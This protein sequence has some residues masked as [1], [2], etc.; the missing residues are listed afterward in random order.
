MQR[1]IA[2][3]DGAAALALVQPC[4][5]DK[6]E[7]FI[8][9]LIVCVPREAKVPCRPVTFQQLS[10]QSDVVLR[11]IQRI[12]DKGKRNVLSFGYACVN[13]TS[14][15]RVR[16]APNIC[17]Y[18]PNPTTAT[19]KNSV[20]WKTLLSRIGDDIMMYLLEFCSLFMLVPPSC[21]FQ[22][23]GVPIYSLLTSGTGRSSIWLRQRPVQYRCNSLLQCIQKKVRFYKGFLSKSRKWKERLSGDG[24][25]VAHVALDTESSSWKHRK[26]LCVPGCKSAKRA[27]LEVDVGRWTSQEIVT[28]EVKSLKRFLN[29][30][31]V[32]SPAKRLKG[33]QLSASVE[34]VALHP[35]A[36]DRLHVENKSNESP[37]ITKQSG[38]TIDQPNK[39]VL[40]WK[41]KDGKIDKCKPNYLK[42]SAQL[43]TVEESTNADYKRMDL[44]TVAKT[45]E[46][47]EGR[48]I[49][50]NRS[51]HLMPIQEIISSDKDIYST[52]VEGEA[53]EYTRL[54]AK[55]TVT[56]YEPG[57]SCVN[58]T[59]A[60]TGEPKKCK[61]IG[62]ARSR[63]S[64]QD[65]RF[66]NRSTSN[67]HST[68]ST[69]GKDTYW[70]DAKADGQSRGMVDGLAN[71]IFAGAP[72]HTSIDA[73][74][75]KNG[76][77]WGAIYIERRNIMYCSNNRECLPNAFI[78]NRL[79]DISTGGQRLVETIFLNNNTFGKK[80]T[81][82]QPSNYWRKKRFPKRY[83]QMRNIFFRLLRNHERCP[84]LLLL[85][86]SCLVNTQKGSKSFNA[87]NAVRKAKSG[88]E[89]NSFPTMKVACRPFSSNDAGLKINHPSGSTIHLIEKQDQLLN[90]NLD[91][92]IS[93][94]KDLLGH[95]STI[96]SHLEVQTDAWRSSELPGMCS[97]LSYLPEGPAMK[98][99]ANEKT[100][101]S[102]DFDRNEESSSSHNDLM[103]LLN[104]YSS[105]LQVH[106]FV[107]DCLLKVVPDELWG[108][109]HNKC[110]FLRNVKKFISL[111][112]F[113]RFSCNELMWK[114]RVNDCTWLQ[115]T[116]DQQSVPAS[117]HQLRE[118]ILSK[119]LF[120]LMDTYVVHL[121]KSFFYVTETTFMKNMLF[122]YRKCVWNEVQAIGVRNHLAK[123]QLRPVSLKLVEQRQ[124]Q[125]TI[126]PPSSLRFIP[127]KNGLRP[128][129]KMRNITGPI[130]SVKGSSFRKIQYSD[131][132][133]KVL[134]GVLNYESHKNPTLLGSS[135]FGLDDTYK[136]WREFVL[137][138]LKAGK[139]RE[140]HPYYFVKADVT[141][142]YD[143]IP[144]AK[145]MEV[146]SGILDPKVQESY[147]SRRYTKVWM[148]STGQIRKSFKRQVSTMMDLLPNMKEFVSHLQQHTSLQNAVLVEQ[149][150]TLNESAGQMFTHFKQT[151][152][153][154][155][156]RIGDKYYV[157]CCGIPQ[158]SLLSTLLCSLCYGDMENKFFSGIQEDGLMLRLIDDFLLITPHLS[159]AKRFLRILAAGIPEYGC[160]I[161][162]HKT[163]VN[164]A[165]D[166]NLPG[167]SKAK[168]LPEHCLFPWCGLLFDTQTLEVYCDYSSYAN[169][170]IRSSLTFNCSSK[171]GQNMRRKLLAVLKLKCHQIFLDLEINTL[172]TVSINVYKIFLLQAYRTISRTA[173]C[174]GDKQP[175]F[176]QDSPSSF[177]IDCTIFMGSMLV[178]YD[179]HLDK[180]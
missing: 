78:L 121:L 97:Q 88:N 140:T 52:E 38:I 138:S 82:E 116:K 175:H 101:K 24:D 110:R 105:P 152:E 20:L 47:I 134:F 85:T 118:E 96:R 84:Y 2:E 150:L 89:S 16:S 73:A 131:S 17:S 5:P 113:D 64:N 31:K 102:R 55:N 173:H 145:L 58:S 122:Y 126:P 61:E 95:D 93:T 39:G 144:H 71:R 143:A 162:P 136:T 7:R 81:Q 69:T 156:I 164:F 149:G 158:G 75:V 56:G 65:G 114:M 42:C 177:C 139:V 107:R 18:Q 72:P 155:T 25:R 6:Y 45:S 141:G 22:I 130:T 41:G 27:R 108:S 14:S 129:V 117:E 29:D 92:H 146:I 70:K 67:I 8:S 40:E 33:S 165:L 35:T 171:A 137:R 50:S 63:K 142:A 104:Q 109:N 32:E 151:I 180:E 83:W 147:C 103:Q 19:V 60:E 133:I 26:T 68:K 90:K 10:T 169:I 87:S 3:M 30:D 43:S 161:S 9:H 94:R 66:T 51:G 154:N 115:L 167:C 124:R 128:V 62:R 100:S 37:E 179:S 106:R 46:L 168:S 79:Q 148:D 120:W 77:T 11:V 1:F 132:Q 98:H 119:F 125:K 170:S 44:E 49:K 76:R 99:K 153:N 34:G 166:E 123:V 127:K 157:Q 80:K 163:V 36:C 48:G 160:F 86:R 135:V 53:S 13:E 178:F 174:N 111:G 57:K 112:K 54:K 176:I 28:A 12:C 159:Q 91:D 4:D 23:C 21:C 15:I 74:A 172:R 59:V